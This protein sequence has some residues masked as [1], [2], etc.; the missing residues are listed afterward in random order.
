DSGSRRWWSIIGAIAE[1]Q[2]NLANL[3]AF[4]RAKPLEHASTY[5][6][7]SEG[8]SLVVKNIFFQPTPP[9]APQPP[10]TIPFHN[11]PQFIQGEGRVVDPSESVYQALAQFI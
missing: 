8:G 9:T 10:P 1:E 4:N 11:P 6:M 2:R 7:S 3:P 5:D